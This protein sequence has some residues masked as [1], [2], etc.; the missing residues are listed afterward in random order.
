MTFPTL[1]WI[2]SAT[3]PDAELITQEEDTKERKGTE[4]LGLVLE[5]SLALRLPGTYQASVCY[6]H[7]PGQDFHPAR[8][9]V[10]SENDWEETEKPGAAY[11]GQTLLLHPGHTMRGLQG[12]L[13][14]SGDS[15]HPRTAGNLLLFL[16]L[17]ERI[18]IQMPQQFM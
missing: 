18:C 13:V 1:L 6:G 5:V 4:T 2:G 8:N 14:G 7:S 3:C 17:C 12:S 16:Q 15:G 9:T 10:S 11:S